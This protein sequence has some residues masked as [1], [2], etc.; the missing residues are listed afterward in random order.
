[1]ADSRLWT[2]QK[3]GRENSIVYPVFDNES[4]CP[5]KLLGLVQKSYHAGNFCFVLFCFCSV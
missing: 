3:D 2:Q 5:I 1:M 4:N